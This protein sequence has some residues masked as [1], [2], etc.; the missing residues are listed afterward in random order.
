MRR[1][2]PD[3]VPLLELAFSVDVLIVCYNPLSAWSFLRILPTR[4]ETSFLLLDES[5]DPSTS[6]RII[7]RKVDTG[8]S[9]T[10]P[11]RLRDFLSTQIALCVKQQASELGYALTLKYVYDVIERA[12]KTRSSVSTL[13][14]T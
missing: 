1:S 9:S 11:L 10:S 7:H 2:I 3:D 8:P 5:S 4:L 14:M 13:A 12:G 6:T